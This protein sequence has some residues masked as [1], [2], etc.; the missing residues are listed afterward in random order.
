MPTGNVTEDLKLDL[1]WYLFLLLLLFSLTYFFCAQ[2]PNVC[3]DYLWNLLDITSKLCAVTK[4]VIFHTSYP[5]MCIVCPYQILPP[6]DNPIAVNKCYYYYYYYYICVC[7]CVY[8]YIYIYIYSSKD[9]V[10]VAI[11]LFVKDIF[12]AAVLLCYILQ[13]DYVTESYFSKFCLQYHLTRSCIHHWSSH[14][15]SLTM[16]TGSK[17]KWPRP[18]PFNTH[19]TKHTNT[20]WWLL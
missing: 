11:R 3:T 5:G 18:L 14:C 9:L 8:M 10:A 17:F 7:V 20:A 6:G 2:L 16:S 13:T 12:S 1:V 15:N 4:L 19:I